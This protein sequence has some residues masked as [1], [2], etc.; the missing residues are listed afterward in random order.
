MCFLKKVASKLCNTIQYLTD[1][2]CN[3]GF[4]GSLLFLFLASSLALFCCIILQY[5]IPKDIQA[6]SLLISSFSMI[7]S[8]ATVFTLFKEYNRTREK[9]TGF[10]T[11]KK[12]DNLEDI[13]E[14]EFDIT[15]NLNKFISLEFIDKGSKWRKEDFECIKKEWNNKDNND[16]GDYA[17]S[18]IKPIFINKQTNLEFFIYMTKDKIFHRTLSIPPFCENFKFTLYVS[19]RCSIE[20]KN[21]KTITIFTSKDNFFTFKVKQ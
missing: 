1:N 5:K 16:K 14:I 4:I 2:I 13:F 3:L 18:V 21:I 17:N 6:L 8:S 11:F 19:G 10:C 12:H 15:N 20:E 7:G 9:L